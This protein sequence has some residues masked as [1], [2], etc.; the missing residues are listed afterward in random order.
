MDN[1]DAVSII[2]VVCVICAGICFG[3]HFDS[4]WL[5]VGVSCA[6]WVLMPQV[7]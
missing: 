2:G 1:R 5:G 6:V 3:M 7:Q 4:A